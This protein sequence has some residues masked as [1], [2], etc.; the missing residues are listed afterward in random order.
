[1]DEEAVMTNTLVFLHEHG[2]K[3]ARDYLCYLSKQHNVD[4]EV[5]RQL[6]LCYEDPQDLMAKLPGSIE[7]WKKF[8]KVK[9][10]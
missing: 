4:L 3:S 8:G 10:I 9:N 6:A 2:W 7:E 1:M 5:V